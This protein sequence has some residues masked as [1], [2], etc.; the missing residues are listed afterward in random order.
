MYGRRQGASEQC[1]GRME[2][3]RNRPL[4][5]VYAMYMRN[6]FV[7]LSPKVRTPNPIL[8]RSPSKPE[9]GKQSSIEASRGGQ[10]QRADRK[11]S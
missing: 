7:S 11:A 8:T 5:L 4:L 6:T 9:G 2:G 10:K 1:S 3:R